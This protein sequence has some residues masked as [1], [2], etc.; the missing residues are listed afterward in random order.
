MKRFLLAC[1]ALV[2]SASAALAQTSAGSPVNQVPQIGVSTAYLSRASYSAVWIGLAPAATT[3]DL[4]CIAA[5]STKTVRLQ[6]IKLSGSAGTTLSLP[7][8][9]LRRASL[10][11]GGTAAST[12]ANPANTIGKRDNNNVA[13]TA[14]LVSYTANPTIN[15]TSPTYLDSAQL[16]VS[17]TTMATVS[18][19]VT[20]DWAKDTEN[21][22]QP[23]VL[24]AGSTQQICVNFNSTSLSSGLITGSITWTEE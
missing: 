17:L 15:D 22:V 23:P 21:F 1:S 9:V 19:P 20:F 18:I 12:T 10:D 3:T 2:L 6:N 5:S 16:A 24:A 8:T 11:S 14:T 13:S 4:I 7:V